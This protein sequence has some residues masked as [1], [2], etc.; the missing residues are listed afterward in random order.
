[1]NPQ[2]PRIAAW[3]LRHFGCSPNNDAV[4][5]DLDERYQRGRPAAWY[6]KQVA[7]TITA[8]LFKE[9]SSHK[10]LAVRALLIGAGVFFAS[11]Y[12]FYF[13]QDVLIGLASWSRFWRHEWIPLML[14]MGAVTVRGLFGGWLVATARRQSRA[15]VLAYAA[16]FAVVQIEWLVSAVLRGTT[17]DFIYG[18]CFIVITPATI[19]AGGGVFSSYPNIDGEQNRTAF[20]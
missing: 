18:I 20:G 17:A 13:M 12:A 6:W 14:H 19:L 16:C 3:L 9:M 1:M 15:M 8:S 7:I 11:R 2:P 5:G 10:V 4:I